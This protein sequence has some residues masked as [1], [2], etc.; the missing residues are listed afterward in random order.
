MNSIHDLGG[1][2]GFAL[3]ER[4]Q[5]F[6]LREDWERQVWGLALSLWS[7]VI[8]GYTDGMSRAHIERLPPKLYISMPY[9][10]KWLQAQENALVGGGLVTRGELD[11]PDGPL[12]ASGVQNFVPA[13]P[14]DVTAFLTG[15]SSYEVSATTKPQFEVGD[16]VVVKNEHPTWHTRAPRYTRGHRG[17]IQKHH[18]VHVFEDGIPKD[19]HPGPQ[20]LYTVTFTAKELWGERGNVNDR[21]NAEF[22]EYHLE[23][24]A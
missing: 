5:D 23:P 18:G 20:H 12:T 8:P 22:W 1:M 10:A 13:G 21:I 2:D 15:D 9:F 19:L 11:D 3:K 6:P 14:A 4:D 7:K 16:V 24:A 17:I